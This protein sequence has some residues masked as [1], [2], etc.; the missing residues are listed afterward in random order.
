MNQNAKKDTLLILKYIGEDFWSRP[1]YQ[2]QFDYLW[3][4]IELGN[5]KIPSLYSV[6]NNEFDGEPLAPIRDKY[7]IREPRESEDPQQAFQYM[8]L[9]RLRSDCDYY[10][11]YGQRNPDRL[12]EKSETAHIEVMKKI[13][14]SFPLDKKPAWLTWDKILEYEKAM[15]K[16]Q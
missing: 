10:L 12:H 16:D 1:V 6:T 14:N 8:M 11:G 4:D 3:K 5:K 15:C 7:I 13:W 9:D 2:D